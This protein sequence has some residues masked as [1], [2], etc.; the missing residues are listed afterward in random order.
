MVI[1]ISSLLSFVNSDGMILYLVQC[2]SL[3]RILVFSSL[4]GCDRLVIRAKAHTPAIVDTEFEPEEAPSEIEEFLPLVY[5]APLT[6]E[7]FEVS[8]PSDTRITSSHSS[9]SSDSTALLSP[10]LPHTEREGSED[11]D[12]GSEDEGLGSE[13]EEEE[14]AP[15]VQHQ[16]I[17]VMDTATNKPLGLGYGA[18]RRRELALGEGSVPSTFEIGQSSRSLLEQQRVEETPTPRPRVRTTWVDPVDGTVYTDIPV[19][20]PPARLPV[21][22]P[23]SPEWSSGSLPVSPSS[24]TVPTLVASPVTTPAATIAVDED[25]FLEVGAQLEL[26]GSKLHDHTQRLDALPPT[27]FEGYDMDLREL[28]TRSRDVKDEIFSQ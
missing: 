26:Y 28:Y 19:D 13:E 10:D 16:A 27:L 6:D 8:E 21:Q 12:P 18:L 2:E 5:R 23:P 1:L 25:E 9:A 7:E 17:L 15:K 4:T 24:L 20:V 3:C 14:A 11:E 22:T